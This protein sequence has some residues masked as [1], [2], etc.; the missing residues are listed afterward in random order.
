[1][2]KPIIFCILHI[3]TY[4]FVSD[5]YGKS[6]GDKP[7]LNTS[8]HEL[9]Q[10]ILYSNPT[11]NWFKKEL[12]KI[13]DHKEDLAFEIRKTLE[14]PSLHID[15]FGKIC[16]LSYYVSP[17]FEAEVALKIINHPSSIEYDIYFVSSREFRNHFRAEPDLLES[18]HKQLLSQGRIEKNSDISKKWEA[19][20]SEFKR[21]QRKREKRNEGLQINKNIIKN[22]NENNFHLTKIF[23]M[24]KP[25]HKCLI[26]FIIFMIMALVYVKRR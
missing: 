12:E 21:D 22:Q 20:I 6:E 13:K 26:I 5:A 11:S 4:V 8:I 14:E 18:T 10:G 16:L 3:F 23:E 2:K 24:N 19:S 17:A 7:A 1:M 9:Y 25:I 15:T